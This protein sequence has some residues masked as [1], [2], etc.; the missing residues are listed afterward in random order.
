MIVSKMVN[1][2][3]NI[4]NVMGNLESGEAICIE[5]TFVNPEIIREDIEDE[6]YK[7]V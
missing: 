2:I 1:S 7:V 4:D 6:E 3:E 5:K